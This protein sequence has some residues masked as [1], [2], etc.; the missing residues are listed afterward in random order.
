MK[1]LTESGCCNVFE[2]LQLKLEKKTIINKIIINK[3]NS[4]QVE[5]YNQKKIHVVKRL[6]C[7]I[8]LFGLINSLLFVY[9]K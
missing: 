2:N 1:Y 4:E 3:I 6:L 9:L 5:I 8:I 7:L